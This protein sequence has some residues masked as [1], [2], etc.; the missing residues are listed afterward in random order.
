MSGI[1]EATAI[2]LTAG[3]RTELEGLARSTKTEYRMRQRAR[4]VLLAAEG[5]KTRAI[6]RAVGCTTGTASKWRVRY[7]EKRLAGLDES[8]D[9]GA[10]PKY[11]PETDRRI[12]AFFGS[13]AAG[14]ARAL[15]RPPAGGGTRRCRCSICLALSASA[16][17]RS[18]RT[19]ILV[20]KQRSRVR[21]QGRR[22]GRS[23]P[24]AARERDRH[25]CR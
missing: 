5:M 7:A 10:E 14:R 16:E 6:G 21:R 4:I 22:C 3:E 8:G 17:G 18:C 19:Q 1:T 23:L 25:L 11:G 20:R 2:T 13:V 9:R 15:D 12:L 24:G